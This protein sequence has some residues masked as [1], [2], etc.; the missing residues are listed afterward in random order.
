TTHR[1]T[2]TSPRSIR[3][4]CASVPASVVAALFPLSVSRFSRFRSALISAADWQRA[5]RSFSS[6]LLMISSSLGGKSG[7]N[8]MAGAGAR[9]RIDS[10]ITPD[11]SVTMGRFD[12]GVAEG[13]RAQELD[14]LSQHIAGFLGY[15]YLAAGRYD[16]S[17]SQFEKAIELDPTAMWLH[18]ELGWAYARKGMYAQ[19]IAEHERMGERAYAVSGENQVVA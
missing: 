9:L 3:P 17:I 6:G 15:Q 16:E 5:S 1:T 4:Q 7:F 8:L 2:A 10:K 11:V 13:R 14:P 18:A 12:E 19:A